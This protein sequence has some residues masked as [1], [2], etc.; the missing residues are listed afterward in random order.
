MQTNQDTRFEGTESF[1]VA[2]AGGLTYTVD[3][4]NNG[5]TGVILDDDPAPLVSVVATDGA[6][7]ETVDGTDFTFTFHRTGDLSQS[8]TVNYTIVPAA[9]DGATP[10]ADFPAQTGTITFAAGAATAVLAFSAIDDALVENTEHFS[11]V[12]GAGSGYQVDIAERDCERLDHRQRRGTDLTITGT[13]GNDDGVSNP[14]LVGGAGNDTINALAGDDVLIGNG[15]NDVLNGDAGRDRMTG[16]AGNDTLNGGVRFRYRGLYRRDRGDHRRLRRRHRHGRRVGRQRHA[17]EHRRP[18]GNELRRHLRRQQLFEHQPERRGR[19]LRPA[20][21][22]RA[23]RAASTSSRATAAPI[24]SRA[25][26]TPGSATR[27]R[28]RP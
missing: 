16:G 27:A 25:T 13:P 10:G 11:V 5:S 6:G 9:T 22:L 17:D 21:R 20:R 15:G 24:S 1:P 14:T 28:P 2:L 12:V 19:R 26:A 18:E 8:L 23:S 4:V 3:P 7:T